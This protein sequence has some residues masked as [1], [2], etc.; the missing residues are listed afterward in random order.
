[1]RPSF[2]LLRVLRDGLTQQMFPA[3]RVGTAPCGS[4][5]R[6]KEE[7]LKDEEK[8]QKRRGEASGLGGRG[9]DKAKP[10]PTWCHLANRRSLSGSKLCARRRRR[11][12][13]R[14]A[15]DGPKHPIPESQIADCGNH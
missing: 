7:F 1:M 6:V 3:G 10:F 2:L 14:H 4:R 9:L 8:A 15:Y 13:S 11:T 5:L 12:R